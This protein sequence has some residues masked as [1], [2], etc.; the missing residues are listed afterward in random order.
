LT[1]S[2]PADLQTFSS[3]AGAF[4]RRNVT[5][6]ELELDSVKISV[7]RSVA[8]SD[9]LPRNAP[10]WIQGTA[11]SATQ[12]VGNKPGELARKVPVVNRVLNSTNA[13]I[14][15]LRDSVNNAAANF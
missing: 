1:S 12:A 6:A 10:N 2:V 15:A 4:V 7:P 8:L 3:S 13:H 11:Q 5:S 14:A 9:W